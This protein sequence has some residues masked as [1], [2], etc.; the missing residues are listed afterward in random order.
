MPSSAV[1][2][3]QQQQQQQT[4]VNQNNHL[5]SSSEKH[6]ISMF[7]L[8]FHMF[9]YIY[10]LNTRLCIYFLLLIKRLLRFLSGFWSFIFFTLRG[11]RK[12]VKKNKM[13]IIFWII[14]NFYFSLFNFNQL[15]III[16]LFNHYHFIDY[17]C[18]SL[19]CF[20]FINNKYFF[21]FF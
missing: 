15:N 11:S 17:V 4:L 20:F 10:L 2:R 7:R 12:K 9:N 6:T 16:V 21:F 8:F 5:N 13:K 19:F 3:V 18:F 14:I 1:I